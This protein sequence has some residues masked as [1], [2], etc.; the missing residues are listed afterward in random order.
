MLKD[1]RD[2]SRPRPCRFYLLSMAA[3][4]ACL[5]FIIAAPDPVHGNTDFP[6]PDKE[7]LKISLQ[8]SGIYRITGNDLSSA[9]IDPSMIDP[10]GFRLF[11]GDTE[12]PFSITSTG[13]TVSA[14]D[15]I[16]FFAGGYS[17]QYTQTDAYWLY[18]SQTAAPMRMETTD[19]TPGN[20][21]HIG[22]DTRS[23]VIEQNSIIWPQTP[24]A[25]EADYWFWQKFTSPQT[26]SFSFSLAEPLSRGEATLYIELQG[27]SG[28]THR[29]EFSVNGHYAGETMWNATE[30]DT[31]VVAVPQTLLR[32]G[33]NTLEIT[34][35]NDGADTPDVFYFNRIRITY[36]R[37]LAALD[38]RLEFSI[39]SENGTDITVSG[40]TG[41]DILAYNVSDADAPAELSKILVDSG[42]GNYAA[43]FSCPIGNHSLFA[44]TADAV[45]TPD[46]I[47]LTPPS[48]LVNASNGADYILITGRHLLPATQ[49][50]LKLRRLQGM[51]VEAVSVE[52]IYDTFSGG[53]FNPE[54]IRDFLAY[55]F[56]NWQSPRPGYVLLVGDATI[57]FFDHFNTGKENVIPPLLFNAPGLGLTPTD[58]LYAC[59]AH[60]DEVPDLFIG[61][62]PGHTTDAVAAVANK[63]ILYETAAVNDLH[64]ALL[65]ADDDSRFEALND[66]LAEYLPADMA[67]NKVYA[68]NY[69]RVP[70][71][72]QAILDH[73]D[74][75]MLLTN[76]VG[77]GDV[78]RWGV[79]PDNSSDFLLTP[80][81]LDDL[82][83]EGPRTFVVAMDCLNGYFAQPGEYSLAEEWV[84]KPNKGA[85]GFFAPSGLGFE[86]DYRRL[87]QTL[88]SLIFHRYENQLGAI[89]SSAKI[90]VYQAGASESILNSFNLIGDP[91]T[92]LAVY[93]DDANPIRVYT[94]YA[95][96]AAGGAI[97][98]AGTIP[99]FEGDSETFII[100]ADSG[101]TI[102][103]VTVDGVSKGAISTYT[104]QGIT[105]DH[106][107][108]A[109]FTTPAAPDSEGGGGGGGGCFIQAVSCRN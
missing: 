17:D 105:S 26:A 25:P 107:I 91:A 96:A 94:V 20:G 69:T 23:Q 45:L 43:T 6:R 50:L 72:T 2:G 61:R 82:T 49:K 102:E 85:I 83:D 54:A 99:V 71:A 104:F 3:R 78:T 67:V 22:T 53:R 9:G 31:A 28:S 41:R 16:R 24:N 73:V 52:D 75:G 88:F 42:S 12:I 29:A 58:N 59:V 38:N 40:F 108:S 63:L 11:H 35:V 93:R 89:A 44:T 77:H 15:E 101:R 46:A 5:L 57:D 27:A 109:S 48:N 60:D 51:R 32:N 36:Q 106:T 90:E 37:P 10:T 100:T 64:G 8:A 39:S 68:G 34:A 14:Q 87:N 18:W 56:D 70:T 86:W 84:L 97:S 21:S 66:S 92:R 103:D 19:A 55:T 33:N 62:I 4:I 1:V 81:H 65:I 74:Q 80:S 13:Q 79:R 76:Y 47:V 98:S 30:A 7:A 95:N